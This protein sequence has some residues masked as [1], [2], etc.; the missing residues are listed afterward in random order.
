MS[1]TMIGDHRE[2]MAE[3]SS[4]ELCEPSSEMDDMPDLV[5]LPKEE[6]DGSGERR[7]H[8]NYARKKH[9]R[10]VF[11]EMPDEAA[12]APLPE[13]MSPGVHARLG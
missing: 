2:R 5:E 1:W 13:E 4:Q 11:T 7:L 12:R 10:I 8:I 6:E 3:A 9:Y